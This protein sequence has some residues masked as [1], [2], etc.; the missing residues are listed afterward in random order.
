VLW[1]KKVKV[2]TTQ[3]SSCNLQ[4]IL[5]YKPPPMVNNKGQLGDVKILLKLS[6]TMKK[7][8]AIDLFNVKI[9]SKP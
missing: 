5:T 8:S 7:S 1:A 9:T 3:R 4:Y 6:Y 2:H